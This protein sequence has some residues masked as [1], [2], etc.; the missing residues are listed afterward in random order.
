MKRILSVLLTV[1]LLVSCALPVSAASRKTYIPK[2]MTDSVTGGQ[3]TFTYNTDTKALTVAQKGKTGRLGFN[4]TDPAYLLPLEMCGNP[5]RQN[6]CLLDNK[7][8]DVVFAMTPSVTNGKVKQIIT[9]GNV[10]R[11]FV[12]NDKG[13]ITRI[14]STGTTSRYAY[15]VHGNLTGISLEDSAKFG[16]GDNSKYYYSYKEQKLS[17]YKWELYQ[18]WGKD[19]ITLNNTGRLR[20]E[21]YK[22]K[23]GNTN[24]V[25]YTYGEANHPTRISY[26]STDKNGKTVFTAT[27]TLTYNR[28]G[29]LTAVSY[30]NSN[31]QT[32]RYT[33][34]WQG[35]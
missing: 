19:K 7:W 27:T 20:T 16:G 5:N 25:R 34:T 1:L 21:T 3:Y 12:R 9:P 31:K 10:S 8:D 30:S 14:N 32:A 23:N 17:G 33:V 28:Y 13:L 35:I 24:T 6:I 22:A 2:T 18:Y 4:A 29:Y 15:D 11:K 26:T